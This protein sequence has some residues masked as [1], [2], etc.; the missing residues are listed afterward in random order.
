MALG[1]YVY[2]LLA[3]VLLI[4]FFVVFFAGLFSSFIA[5]FTSATFSIPVVLPPRAPAV[6]YA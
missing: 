1:Q 4:V 2:F 6:Q 3:G 5:R